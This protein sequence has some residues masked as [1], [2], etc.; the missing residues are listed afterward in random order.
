MAAVVLGAVVMPGAVVDV[1]AA[2]CVGALVV[3]VGWEDREGVAAEVV[4]GVAVMLGVAVIVVGAAV[5]VVGVGVAN[6]PSFGGAVCAL[7]V[8]RPTVRLAPLMLWSAPLQVPS[9]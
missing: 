5:C 7:N 1:G 3:V 2:D 4:L 8:S 9:K 6:S